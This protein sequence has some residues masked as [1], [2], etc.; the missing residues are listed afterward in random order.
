MSVNENVELLREWIVRF[1]GEERKGSP[2][3]TVSASRGQGYDEN[4]N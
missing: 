3:R 2:K 4:L 1:Q